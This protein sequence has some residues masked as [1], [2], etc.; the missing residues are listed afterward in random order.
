MKF[1]APLLRGTLIKRYKRF[2]ADVLLEAP[3]PD[4]RR[5]IVAHCA[6]S[7]SMLTVCD[8]GSEVWVSP[9]ANPDRK[10]QFSW[11]LIRVGRSLVGINT[12]HPNK[13]AA[14]AIADGTIVE[15]QSYATMRR[16]VKY[17]QNS[18]IDLL[19]ESP[20]RAPCFV[21][22]KNVTLVRGRGFAEFPDSV[23]ARG[24]KHLNE[25]I[26]QVKLGNRAVML[27]LAQRA[28]C[29]NFAAAADIDPAYANGLIDAA[30]AGV[31]VLAYGCR[32]TSKDIKVLRPIAFS[33]VTGN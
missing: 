25:L 16:E 5:E 11:E 9:A 3:L 15:L 30:R 29:T 20:G 19:L 10:L 22:V 4:G 28:D 7:G 27:Y 12:M 26:D 1:P 6:N 14:E 31:E 32:V 13:L 24:A 21:E 23:T 33:S 18:R 8:P 17:G 2:L